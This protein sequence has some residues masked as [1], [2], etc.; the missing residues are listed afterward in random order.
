V[1]DLVAFC[2]SVRVA[3]L[4]VGV[5]RSDGT[6]NGQLTLSSADRED[7]TAYLIGRAWELSQRFDGRGRLAGFLTQRLH[8][9]CTDWTRAR[10]GSTRWGPVAVFTPTADPGVYVT[11]TWL[12]AEFDDSDA[13]DLEAA[14]AGTR[15]ALELIR[16]LIDGETESVKQIAERAQVEPS[17]VT[18]AL[19]LVRA[20]ARRQGLE[21]DDEER[22]ALADQVRGLREQRMTYPQIATMLGLPSSHTASALIRDYHPELIKR[23]RRS[24]QA[25]RKPQVIVNAPMKSR[26]GQRNPCVYCKTPTIFLRAIAGSNS[27]QP[28]WED[29]CADCGERPARRQQLAMTAA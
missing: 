8:F 26:D 13:L 27:T 5:K 17:Q 7:L 25:E 21:P 9:A 2:G 12:D 23:Q 28:E 22:H 10:F 4:G 16:P 14:P 11:G 1:G 6:V 24:A 29:C 3:H 18:N 20:A 15:E 19:A